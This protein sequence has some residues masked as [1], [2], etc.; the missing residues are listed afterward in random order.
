MARLLAFIDIFVDSP[1]LGEVVD[2]LTE[3]PNVEEIYEVTGEY[4]VVTLVSTEGIEEFRDFLKNK[5]LKIPGIKSTVTSIVLHAAK[6][7][8]NHTGT[9]KQ[10]NSTSQ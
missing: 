8:R 3:F 7:H 4:D 6:G 2:A 10:R 9:E 1:L 5:V